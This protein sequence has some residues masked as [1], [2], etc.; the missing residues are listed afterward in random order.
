MKFKLSNEQDEPIIEITTEHTET[1]NV[2]IKANGINIIHITKKGQIIGMKLWEDGEAY[3]KLKALGFQ[4]EKENIS[5]LTAWTKI[6]G[7]KL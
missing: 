3:L 6:K 1:G 4:F 5:E 2:L 7:L